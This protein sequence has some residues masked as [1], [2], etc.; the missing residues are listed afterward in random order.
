MTI[1][2]QPGDS[3]RPSAVVGGLGLVQIL[4]W[5]T[6]YY[7]PAVLA[8]PMA[9]A[10]GWSLSFVVGGFSLA[11]FVSGLA[12]PS[13]GR[14]ID[15]HGGRP[16]LAAGAVVLAAGLTALG[17]ATSLVVFFAA[18]LVIGLAMSASLYDAAFSTLGRLYGS[19]A[20]RAITA[21]TLFGGFASTVCW[22]LSAYLVETLGWRGTCFTYAGFQLAISLPIVLFLI[23][24][25][26]AKHRDAENPS[27]SKAKLKLASRP[28]RRSFLLLAA[29]LMIGGTIATLFSVHLLTL[30]QAKGITLAAAVS[31]GALVGPSQVGARV[32][33]MALGRHYHPLWTL[34]AST[35]LIATGTFLLFFDLPITL[36]AIALYGA[37]NGIWSI[38]K[39]TVPLAIFGPA[40]YPVMMGQLAMPGLIAQSA[41]PFIGA[42]V[43]E[44]GGAQWTVAL[45]VALALANVALIAGLARIN[46][47]HP[48]R[49]PPDL[50]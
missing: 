26:A 39:G 34:A 12:A 23:P 42:V 50:S 17:L 3:R 1:L 7:L 38:A 6:S 36:A 27:A 16:V 32:F 10:T 47:A 48:Q 41:A 46:S 24:R 4:A 25:E 45:L 22:P 29:M 28:E 35:A 5:G 44:H 11:L 15:S 9:A 33:E 18:W 37:G 8:A 21:L 20:R 43:L 13:V 30:L 49:K 2:D 19:G 31:L 14:M 40:R